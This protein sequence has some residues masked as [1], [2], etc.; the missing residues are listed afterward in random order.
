LN[1]LFIKINYR[2]LL[3]AGA[4]CV[5]F[6]GELMAGKRLLPQFGGAASV[7]CCT[8]LFFQL[9]LLVAYFGTRWLSRCPTATRHLLL[10]A[11][12][13]SGLLTLLPPLPTANWLPPELQP[14]IALLPFAGLALGLFSATPLLHQQQTDRHDFT[15]YAWSN[16]GALAGLLT[17]PLLIEPFTRLTTQNRVWAV[18]G[19]LICILGLRD[20]TK[21][22][23]AKAPFASNESDSH[24][25]KTKWQWWILPGISGATLLATT[26]QLSYEASAGPLTWALPLALFL[27]TYVWAFSGNRRA[28]CGLIATA[29]LLA[30]IITHIAFPPSSPSLP[31]VMMI[32]PRS[33][34]MLGLL[35][36]A[37]G[38]TML[39]CH[40]WLAA[41]RNENTHG[42]YTATAAGGAIGSALMVL[43]IPH[44]T[45][46]PV[47]FPFLTLLTLCVAGFIWSGRIV[48]PILA[49]VGFVAIGAT[50]I[51]EAAGRAHE[52]ARARTLYSCWRV[53]KKPDQEYYRLISN[54]TIHAEEERGN[55]NA[56]ATYYGPETGLG[57]LLAEK[58]AAQPELSIGVVGLGA[59]TINRWLR[60][61]DSII[62]YE[63]D[64]EAETLA[65]AWFSYLHRERCQIII[66]DGRKT[67]QNQPGP[68]FDI[69]VLD[70]FTGDAVPTHLLTKEAGEIYRRHLKP[71]GALAI[72]ITNSHVQLLPVAEGLAQNMG[73]GCDYTKSS[74]I[75]WATL[76]PNAAPPSGRILAWT[77]EQN[78]IIPVLRHNPQENAA[79]PMTW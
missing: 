26:T 6:Q 37:G 69:L 35:L 36:L 10:A 5:A 58:K 19:A 17:Y 60:P 61:Q 68:Q 41:A 33:A 22:S 56:A 45:N 21:S 3:A 66:G 27:A 23:D 39:L 74:H 11:L 55:T 43:V 4:A 15:I 34:S 12:G 53:T 59:G 28:S 72:H 44:V 14:L 24:L 47:E 18:S 52:V 7:W 46:G 50:L 51:A 31:G 30:L 64:A 29:G 75:E 65:R 40:V 38:A 57:K 76:S 25:G 20:W 2:H 63:I 9:T 42:F 13:L 77:D 16:A 67:L 62:Y 71:G 49:T 78:S 1:R 70:A 73:L 54:T 32:P 48:R 8:L 79:F